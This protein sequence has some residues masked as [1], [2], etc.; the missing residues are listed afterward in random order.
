MSNL[1]FSVAAGTGI[2]ELVKASFNSVSEMATS[3]V[4]SAW[5]K[6]FEDFEPFMNEAYRKN[7]FVRLLSQKDRDVEFYSVYVKSK[8]KCA[9]NTDDDEN[10]IQKIRDGKNIVINGNGGAGKTFFMRHLWMSLFKNEMKYTPIFIELRKLNDISKIDLF[11][12]VRRSISNKKELDD[13]IFS[14]FCDQGRFCFILDGYD[15]VVVSQREALQSQ[16]LDLSSKYPNCR[17]VV[18]SRYER[19]FAGWNGFD[20]YDAVPFDIIQVREL[21]EKVPFDADSKKLFLKKIDKK[22]YDENDSFLSNPL[23]SIMMM[24]TFKENMEIPKRMNIFYEQAFTTLYTW[25]D[26]TKA[27]SRNKCLDIS[28]FQKSF[29]V[30]CLLTYYK[31]KFEFTKTELLNFIK[32]SNNICGFNNDANLVLF[33]YEESVNLLKQE[34]LSYVFIHRSFQ[35]Y[36]SAYAMVH[37]MPGKFSEIVLK[38]R[39]NSDDNVIAMCYEMNRNLVVENYIVPTSGEFEKGLTIEAGDFSHLCAT[40]ILYKFDVSRLID[41]SRFVHSLMFG[42][43][44]IFLELNNLL[45]K[46]KSKEF[47]NIDMN[48]LLQLIFNHSIFEMFS[49]LNGKIATGSSSILSI[50]VTNNDFLV[51]FEGDE[52]FAPNCSQKIIEGYNL[53][54]KKILRK[55]RNIFK[56]IDK[57]IEENLIELREWYNKE[58]LSLSDREKSLADILGI[59]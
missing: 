28:D 53:A 31:E 15:E 39:R 50:G 45:H 7:N 5:Q 33:D 19:R 52:P 10:I 34:G 47:M 17:F 38:L 49:T 56:E 23:L 26:A 16:I 54:I 32:E 2:A 59:S 44:P 14:Y 30:F 36:F 57:K 3:S 20:L 8:F 1:D 58:I 6:V 12:F 13:T 11:S 43:E 9:N 22:F 21:I 27:F 48:I 18:S 4:K 41:V 42:Y 35:E 37:I 55:N 25:H 51:S 40:K 46:I 24:M 29:A